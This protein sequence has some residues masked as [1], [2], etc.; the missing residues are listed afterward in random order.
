MNNLTNIKRFNKSIIVLSLGLALSACGGSSSDDKVIDVVN[1]APT[2]SSSAVT[3]VEFGTLYSYS[4][5]AADADGDTLTM[6]ASS[7]PAWLTFDSATGS[8]SGTPAVSD[9]GD[10]AITL[11]VSDG[12]DEITQSFTVTVTVSVD[13]NNAPVISS[14]SIDAATANA[15]YSYTL[16]ATD[17]DSDSLTMSA[18]TIPAWLAFDPT[19]GILSGT[20]AISDE[21]DHAV[22]L[23]VTDGINEI[24][25]SFSILVSVPTP[26]NTA[27]EITSA[28]LTSATVDAAYT[29]TLTATDADSDTLTM[30][31]DIPTALSWL[32]FD[33]ATGILSGTPTSDDIAATAI[34]LTVNDGTVDTMQTFTITVADEAAGPTTALVV[35][36]DVDNL[37]WPLWGDSAATTSIITDADATYG[38]VANFVITGNTVAGFNNRDADS[39]SFAIP[40]GTTTFEFDLKMTKQADAGAVDWKVKL[41][42][43]TEGDGTEANFN[44]S[45]EG[46]TPVL[47][48]W[49][50]YTFNVGNFNVT[51]IDLVM[52]FPDWSTGTGA[53]YSVD[54]V[55]FNVTPL[56]ETRTPG[57]SGDGA[58]TTTA[59]GID[60]EGT[61]LTWESFDTAPVQ[62]VTNPKTDGINTSTTAALFDIHQ[63][64]G[65]WVGALTQGITSFALDSSNCIVNLDVYKDTISEIHIKFQKNNG[66][67]D[68]GIMWGSHGTVGVANTV[69]NQWETLTF[70]TCHWVGLP[71][72]DIIGALAIFPD[73]TPARSQN[74]MNYLDNIMFTAQGDE[75]IPG[76][77]TLVADPTLAAGDVISLHTSG[78]VYTNITVND[79]N[80]N[81]G[82]G[83]S[84]SD[85]TVAGKTVK[86]VD[87]VNYQGIDFVSTDISGKATLH[88]SIYANSTAAFNVFVITGDAELAITTG[89]LVADSWNEI[90]VDLSATGS[91]TSAFQIKFDGGT[92]QTLWLDNIY[93]H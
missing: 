55:M 65:E 84:I 47:D 53:E 2:I 80:P 82:Q 34:T 23:A 35:F 14:T 28:G 27:P 30:S 19:T 17:T 64:D 85:D 37:D 25:Q 58:T 16:A 32:T 93:F 12:T 78:D 45:N 86:K 36:E 66:V 31:A 39:A 13:I 77:T 67:N 54:N 7:L 24:T 6:S 74:T 73:K 15:D 33:T 83:G 26:V 11:T 81:W 70:D 1:S 18:P 91:L 87:L 41:E 63:S 88:M 40:V 75:V 49:M 51:D 52:I 8:L 62:Y 10:T 72:T 9:A 59:V 57:N 89:P 76:P 90:E 79:W 20:P 42:G 29:Y 21:G 56:D 61:Q 44:T 3:T 5:V 43:S 71:E 38:D 60:F 22:V 4:L 68:D 92:G 48:T 69:V 46:Q 50:H